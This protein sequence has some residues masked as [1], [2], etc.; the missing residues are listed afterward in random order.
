MHLTK[1]Q[2]GGAVSS[3]GSRTNGA[4]MNDRC[5]AA[6]SS[7]YSGQVGRKVVR[8]KLKPDIGLPRIVRLTNAQRKGAPHV[9][10]RCRHRRTPGQDR[11]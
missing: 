7:F 10:T 9:I 6:A 11:D 1:R 2:T 5:P 8:V 3:I 4:P